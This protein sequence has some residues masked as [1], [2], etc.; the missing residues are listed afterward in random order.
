MQQPFCILHSR[1]L[2]LQLIGLHFLG[3]T[4]TGYLLIPPAYPQLHQNIL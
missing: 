2:L 3:Y 1:G 4:F